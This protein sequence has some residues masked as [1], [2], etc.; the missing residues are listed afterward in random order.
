MSGNE[1]VISVKDNGIGIDPKY[2]TEVF[3]AFKRLHP[4][5]KYYGTGL[6]LS[7]C[8]KIV[9]RHHGSIEV[10]ETSALLDGA[11]VKITLPIIEPTK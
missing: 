10:V 1:I 9:E 8:R 11:V 5:E 3:N 4:K 7:L 6:G 2:T